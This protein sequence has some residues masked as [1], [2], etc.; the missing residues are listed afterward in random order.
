MGSNK[1]SKADILRQLREQNTINMR[2]GRKA[3][4]VKKSKKKA[5]K[6]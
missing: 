1:P 5:S 2:E 6:K 4:G 3:L